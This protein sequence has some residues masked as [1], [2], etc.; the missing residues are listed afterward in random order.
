[1]MLLTSQ[2]A[3]GFT[4][5]IKALEKHTPLDT[6]KAIYVLANDVNRD[7]R[8]AIAGFRKRHSN[9]H[10]LHCSPLGL[11]PCVMKMQN[12]VMENHPD[13]VILKMDD[14]MFV[15]P[16]W[17]EPMVEA[18]HYY[19][20]SSVGIISPLIPV[21]MA[22]DNFL[23]RYYQL[24][25]PLEYE[26]KKD[27]FDQFNTEYAQWIWDRFLHHDFHEKLQEYDL[28]PH[29]YIS[30]KDYLSTHCI[31]FDKRVT[32]CINPLP[33]QA[34]FP[35]NDERLINALMQGNY[36]NGSI[37]TGSIV[38]HHAYGSGREH[39][40]KH[41]PFDTI[42]SYLETLNIPARTPLRMVG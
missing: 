21:N 15:T 4:A 2:Y 16:G 10:E 5:C 38:H 11:L 14:D 40:R 24:A 25:Y 8:E 34:E 20:E 1:M 29:K 12:I 18:Y 30:R 35:N 7:H 23:R 17:F 33:L 32:Q 9:V 6:F 27:S 39:F 13:D 41:V 42:L 19:R 26:Q 28:P 31:M 36:V 3:D 22:C 37:V